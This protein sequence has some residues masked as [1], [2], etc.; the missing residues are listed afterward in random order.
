MDGSMSGSVNG[1][2]INTE[3]SQFVTGGDDKVSLSSKLIKS[4]IQRVDSWT[5]QCE[6]LKMAIT[7]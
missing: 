4:T 7:R 3:G 5:I 1:M 6:K 2:V